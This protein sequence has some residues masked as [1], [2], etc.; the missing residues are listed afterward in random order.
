MGWLTRN[1]PFNKALEHYSRLRGLQDSPERYSSELL[2][3]I[4]LCQKALHRLPTDGDA[5]VMLA[6]G[7]QLM[8][9]EAQIAG[10][11]QGYDLS[12]RL[13]GAVIYEWMDVPNWTRNKETGAEV[14]SQIRAYFEVDGLS[15]SQ[16]RM[17]MASLRD[18]LLPMAL[19]KT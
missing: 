19:G 1:D 7:Y 2:E 17:G 11:L 16:V 9:I 3:V 14:L 8:A 13:A 12:M 18:G 5:Y 10:N 4:R 6:N 15:E